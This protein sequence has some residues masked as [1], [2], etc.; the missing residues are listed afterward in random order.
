MFII[1]F[2]RRLDWRRPP[3][4]TVAL[5]LI[6]ALVF[7]LF[8]SQ[9]ER[10]LEVALEYYFSSEL[11][12]LE[13]P[14]Y[15]AYLAGEAAVP[16]G[17][18]A[19][20]QQSAAS[21][22]LL[23]ELQADAAFMRLLR[24]GEIIA[25]AEP[26]YGHW[27]LLRREFDRQLAKVSSFGWGFITS[28]PTW[29]TAF[30]HM[31]LHGNLSHLLGN[32]L[33]LFAVGFLVEGA[34]GRGVFL[35]SYLL[36][37]LG[38]VALY[39]LLTPVSGLPLVGASGAV[40]GLM[41][42]YAVLFGRRR[43]SFFF[44]ALVY[45]DYVRAPALLL[46]GLWLAF[47]L[48]QYFWLAPDS[49]VAYL[50]HVGGLLS[51]ALIALLLRRL[52]QQVDEAYLA[53]QDIEQQRRQRDQQVLEH[54]E[55]LDFAKAVPLLEQQLQQTPADAQLLQQLLTCTH[56]QPASAAYHSAA[57][58]VFT[59]PLAA[60]EQDEFVLQSY[61]SYLRHAQPKPRLPASVIRALM[62]RLLRLPALPEAER[63][64]RVMLKHP[65]AF[66]EA[67]A[68]TLQ[69]ALAVQRRQQQPEAQRY[70]E[71]LLER[72]PGSAEAAIAKQQ[73]A[74]AAGVVRSR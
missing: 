42:M 4:A 27:Q 10:R 55:R 25:V 59:L 6:N 74:R 46:L 35:A 41:G 51:G 38:A 40:S 2:D 47:E 7:V 19:E 26:E 29:P 21:V 56:F 64:L 70:F 36:C 45:F 63:L 68:T 65:Q 67:A 17:A 60:Q 69:L 72:F 37:G 66:P 39:A 52:P 12:A 44:F 13:L 15:Q 11:P 57:H 30:T 5:L 14:R 50:A 23:F 32:L 9:D 16:G 73:L 18:P 24:Q 49:N 1:P 43:I 28:A 33:F 58:R 62:P 53:A 3:W 8:Q 31:F 48:L 34:L 22:Q 54:M 71:L 61:L 20:L